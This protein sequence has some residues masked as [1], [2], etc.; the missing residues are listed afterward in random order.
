MRAHKKLSRT[1][2]YDNQTII[3][4]N[5]IKEIFRRKP[6]GGKYSDKRKEETKHEETEE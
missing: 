3:V 4:S 5:D 1:S 6:Y 2:N